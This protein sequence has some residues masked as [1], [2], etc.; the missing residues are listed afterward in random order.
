MR[1]VCAAPCGDHGGRIS[2]ARSCGSCG[3][4]G[5]GSAR[6]RKN[7]DLGRIDLARLDCALLARLGEV[8]RQ[9]GVPVE[10]G[11]EGSPSR[12]V[13]KGHCGPP[14]WMPAATPTSPSGDAPRSGS[15]GANEGE[16]SRRYGG[17][18][19]A[20]G[21][22]P[23]RARRRHP[24]RAT[25]DVI[26]HCAKCANRHSLR[27]TH[28]ERDDDAAGAAPSAHGKAPVSQE[29]TRGMGDASTAVNP[30]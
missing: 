29:W 6:T 11:A 4:G 28:R 2:C 10:I 25:N 1:I 20:G 3:A 23:A 9:F 7:G 14:T 17:S 26:G 21:G 22:H 12:V 27:H 24:G 5:P 13:Q 15:R 30:P 19:S 18:L 8:V 16:G